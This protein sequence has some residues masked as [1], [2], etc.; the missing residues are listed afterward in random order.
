MIHD[1]ADD[2][3]SRGK[4]LDIRSPFM[5]KIRGPE[6]TAPVPQAPLSAAQRAAL[7][8]GRQLADQV[9][10]KLDAA[11]VAHCRQLAVE[12]DAARTALTSARQELATLPDPAALPIDQAESAILRKLTLER[13]LPGLQERARQASERFG[14]AVAEARARLNIIAQCDVFRAAGALMRE[15]E[16]QIDALEREI[17]DL[18]HALGAAAGALSSWGADSDAHPLRA[19]APPA[20]TVE[21]PPPAKRRG[22]F[23]R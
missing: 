1:D 23:G 11:T 12:H 19:P 5:P 7:T 2:L 15:K 6:W 16:A 22:L 9:I 20:P 21:P 13:V 4:V 3:A 17:A 8:L 10:A 18:Q 14:V